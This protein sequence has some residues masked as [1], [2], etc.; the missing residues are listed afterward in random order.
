MEAS[1]T[2]VHLKHSIF[3]KH[4]DKYEVNEEIKLEIQKNLHLSSKYTRDDNQLILANILLK[5]YGYNII[6][7]ATYKTNALDYELYSVISQFDSSGFAMA[8]LFVE[9]INKKNNAY[10]EIL[11]SFFKALKDSGL[12]QVYF[13]LT[14][15]DFSQISAA[16][17][18]W[19]NIKVQICYWHLKKLF[20]EYESILQDALAIVQEQ[21]A[22]SNTQWTQSV[23]KSFDGIHTIVND[24]KSYRRRNTNS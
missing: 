14:D 13:F 10:I 8:Y 17:Q 1:Y 19:P 23:Y 9:R 20:E 7:D 21:H 24:I 12:D 11:A 5:E 18:I 16:Q 15:K 2:S 3:H 22:A 6:V 4:P